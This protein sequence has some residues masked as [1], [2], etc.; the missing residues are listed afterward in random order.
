MLL[1]QVFFYINMCLLNQQTASVWQ[2]KP[3]PTILPNKWKAFLVWRCRRCH[4]AWNVL[5][6]TPKQNVFF[7]LTCPQTIRGDLKRRRTCNQR[8]NTSSHKRPTNIQPNVV[9]KEYCLVQEQN[10]VN[11]FYAVHSTAIFRTER[12]TSEDGQFLPCGWKK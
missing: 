6:C 3:P 12:K 2:N 11:L 7:K 10:T 8:T 9:H 4:Q 5:L 1:S